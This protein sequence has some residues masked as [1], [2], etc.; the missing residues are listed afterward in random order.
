MAGEGTQSSATTTANAA[1]P[2]QLAAIQKMANILGIDAKKAIAKANIQVEKIE[3]LS[4]KQAAVV[5]K[6]LNQ[7]IASTD[8]NANDANSQ[9]TPPAGC[10]KNAKGCTKVFFSSN[11]GCR[12]GDIV[13]PLCPFSK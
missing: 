5:I 2:T 13:G 11:N 12:C 8:T 6:T 9:F 7:E 10:V 1:A 4:Y 3:D